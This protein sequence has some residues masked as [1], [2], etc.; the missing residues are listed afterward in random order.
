M[1]LNL[2]RNL[3]SDYEV[4]DSILRVLKQNALVLNL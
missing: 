3:E 4:F 1:N 2:F